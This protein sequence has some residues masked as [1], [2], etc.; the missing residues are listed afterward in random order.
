MASEP[1][2]IGQPGE[3]AARIRG[4]PPV[5]GSTKQGGTTVEKELDQ[6][7]AQENESDTGEFEKSREEY[8]QSMAARARGDEDASEEDES[9]LDEF[10]GEE[11]DE[12]SEQGKVPDAIEE[13]LRASE[14]P[15]SVETPPLAQ[16]PP[17]MKLKVDGQEI[18]IHDYN[19]AVT[20]AQKGLHY[21]QQ[22]QALAPY[23]H[24]LKALEA[25]PDLQEELLNRIRGGQ[26]AKKEEK[27]APV[28]EPE[29]KIEIPPMREDETYEEWTQRV[30]KE[31]IPNL[32]RS[33]AERIAGAKAAE[34][35][36][37]ENA[38][39]EEVRRREKILDAVRAD[40]LFNH[41]AQFIRQSIEAGQIPPTVLQAADSDPKTFAWLYD[42]ARKKVASMMAPA[43]TAPLPAV[44]PAAHAETPRS[45]QPRAPHAEAAS[46]RARPSKGSRDY[47]KV[48]EDMEDAKFKELLER[49]KA[50]GAR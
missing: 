30:F 7:L 40:P 41:T 32:V 20:L 29:K 42:S 25:N 23:R 24:V 8:Y 14:Q 22:M 16:K 1:F 10:F 21:T 15:P 37:T 31:E 19:D 11:R 5:S 4:Y 13:P 2:F 48:I 50:G 27:A 18:A 34:I 3:G 44:A 46:G 12:Q 47:V 33:E 6:V 26:P 17:L 39:L 49:V 36:K 45:P 35:F 43:Q 28:A 38:T 9:V